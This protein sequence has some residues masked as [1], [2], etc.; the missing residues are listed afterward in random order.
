MTLVRLWC[1]ELKHLA[2][3]IS[4]LAPPPAPPAPCTTEDDSEEESSPTWPKTHHT[5]KTNN[6]TEIKRRLFFWLLDSTA[7]PNER[8]SSTAVTGCVG[9]ATLRHELYEASG[10]ACPTVFWHFATRA[11]TISLFTL[12]F[13]PTMTVG[14]HET[15][16]NTLFPEA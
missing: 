8:E 10:T 3:S 12:F 13:F 7:K 5:T 1:T 6:S 14:N 16:K 2:Q 15:I 11:V 4:L 9:V